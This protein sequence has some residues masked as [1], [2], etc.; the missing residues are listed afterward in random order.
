M[1]VEAPTG[2]LGGGDGV[3]ITAARSDSLLFA[4][5]AQILAVSLSD[6]R[7]RALTFPQSRRILWELTW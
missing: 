7:N 3:R 6:V 4:K 2:R 1:S 5:P